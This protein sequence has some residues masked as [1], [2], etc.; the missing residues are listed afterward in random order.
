MFIGSNILCD[1]QPGT[2]FSIFSTSA[3]ADAV[4]KRKT[5]RREVRIGSKHNRLY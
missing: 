2:Q 4:W 3:G 1:T 5:K